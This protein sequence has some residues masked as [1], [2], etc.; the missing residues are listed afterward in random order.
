[1]NKF[2]L[3]DKSILGNTDQISS[4]RYFVTMFTLLAAFILLLLCIVHIYMEL[5]I[6]PV[7]LAGSSSITLFGLYYLVRFKNYLLLP[8]TILTIGGLIMLDFTWYVKF[9]SN[10]PVLFFIMIFAALVIWVWKGRLLIILLTLYFVNL[11]VLFYIDYT[12]PDYLF[13]YPV[14]QTKSIDIFISLFFYS[15]LLIIILYLIKR[16]F[17]RQ[18]EKT[19]EINDLYLGIFNNTTIGL[20]QTTPDGK[21][22]SANPELIKMLNFS[23][24]EELLQRDLTQGSYVDISKKKGV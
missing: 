18:K 16:K 1:M 8:K 7:I 19:S 3:L 15:S 12:S 21:V 4:E 10:G 2:D 23:S 5:E 13:E 14:H 9:L 20:Y 22:L 6:A 24:L 11:A 17:I